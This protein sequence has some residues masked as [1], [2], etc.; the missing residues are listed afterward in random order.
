[1]RSTRVEFFQFSRLRGPKRC[2]LAGWSYWYWFSSRRVENEVF[3]LLY[4]FLD[5]NGFFA[6]LFSCLRSIWYLGFIFPW[7][8]F[9]IFVLRFFFCVSS[10]FEIFISKFHNLFTPP[11]I[12]LIIYSIIFID[13]SLSC[14]LSSYFLKF[15][16]TWGCSN[17]FLNIIFY[18][19]NLIYFLF[20]QLI[21][22]KTLISSKCNKTLWILLLKSIKINT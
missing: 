4:L 13:I 14:F 8:F 5:F 21:C 10:F 7:Y 1:V 18:A 19:F 3:F 16:S 22:F 9:F 2:V 11:I 20:F 15:S 17:W 6:I 12:S